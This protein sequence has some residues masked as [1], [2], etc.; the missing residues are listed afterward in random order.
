[1]GGGKYAHI[2][3]QQKIQKMN[4]YG[5]NSRETNPPL[6]FTRKQRSCTLRTSWR[7]TDS[8]RIISY[9]S[10]L[11]LMKLNFCIMTLLPLISL[12]L[13]IILRQPCHQ[14][15]ALQKECIGKRQQLRKWPH[16]L[17]PVCLYVCIRLDTN[18]KCANAAIFTCNAQ[19][20]LNL[21]FARMQ[22]FRS[23]IDLCVRDV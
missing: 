23:S 16:A 15:R 21:Q 4:E 12:L 9:T 17:G 2:R 1:M 22:H 3:Y 6:S 14:Q 18:S 13:I 11:S 8:M 20:N 5:N 10:Q 7:A 19:K